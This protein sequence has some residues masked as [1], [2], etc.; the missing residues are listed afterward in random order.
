MS[1]SSLRARSAIAS[2]SVNI[3]SITLNGLAVF[4][5][6]IQHLFSK[7]ERLPYASP[8]FFLPQSLNIVISALCLIRRATRPV[9]LK[10]DDIFP[11]IAGQPLAGEEAS[12]G[13]GILANC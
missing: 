13:I 11:P 6:V 1:P 10:S 9:N 3:W 4:W 12:S 2:L 7:A 8:S 5:M